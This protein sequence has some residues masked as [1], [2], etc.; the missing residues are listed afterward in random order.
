VEI[1]MLDEDIRFVLLVAAPIGL[2]VIPLYRA[3]RQTRRRERRSADDATVGAVAPQPS[4][5][6]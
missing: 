2:I 5:D 6:A 1:L 3:H 4:G